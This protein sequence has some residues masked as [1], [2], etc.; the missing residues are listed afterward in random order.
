MFLP[1]LVLG[2][3]G[4]TGLICVFLVG[5]KAQKAPVVLTVLAMLAMVSG[6][7]LVTRAS[8]EILT[9]REI[10]KWPTVEGTILKS[11]IIGD[12]A[13][14]PLV[15]YQYSIGGRNYTDS[16]SMGVPPFGNRRVRLNESETIAA[17]YK[18][19]DSVRVYVDPVNLAHSTLYAR[20]D[21]ASY[22]RLTLGAILFGVGL[23]QLAR[24]MRS[25]RGKRRSKGLAAPY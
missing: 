1:L 2:V 6:P 9:A 5:R 17:E 19:G 25:P 22:M 21:W 16:T 24:F 7:L 15:F 14:R 23:F 10:K 8:R 3:A 13:I 12:R 18:V 20:E 4:I 11:E